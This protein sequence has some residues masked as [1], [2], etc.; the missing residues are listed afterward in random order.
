MTMSGTR[1]QA[2]LLVEVV[3]EEEERRAVAECQS[4]VQWDMNADVEDDAA[5]DVQ[6][7]E[8]ERMADAF[9]IVDDNVH[10]EDRGDGAVAE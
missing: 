3:D 10:V 9:P 8:Y 5:E 4:F 6:V 2:T 7:D 1:K